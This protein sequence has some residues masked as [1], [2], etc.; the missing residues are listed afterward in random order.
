MVVKRA[1]IVFMARDDIKP[2]N[3]QPRTP[4]TQGLVE[5]ISGV[6]KDKLSKR[7]EA[8]GNPN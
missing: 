6:M 8:T 1:I 7:I 2:I 5:Q 3:G 4:W